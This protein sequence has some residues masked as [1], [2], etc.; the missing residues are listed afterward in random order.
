M[1]HI[2][3]KPF[4]PILL[5]TSGCFYTC[6]VFSNMSLRDFFNP[7]SLSF[8]EWILFL[9]MNRVLLLCIDSVAQLCCKRPTAYPESRDVDST[10]VFFLFVNCF[11]EN[12]FV[13][14]FS[15]VSWNSMRISRSVQTLDFISGPVGLGFIFILDDL[16]YYIFHRFL[17]ASPYL[18]ASIHRYHHKSTYPRRGYVDAVIEHPVEQVCALVL[19]AVAV[20][21]VAHCIRLHV[22]TLGVHLVLKALFSCWNHTGGEVRFLK[23]VYS[24]HTH[25]IHHAKL[26]YNFGQYLMLWDMLMGTFQE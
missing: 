4:Y 19:Y 26:K 6:I 8:S 9:F 1:D 23:P 20:T 11:V 22:F 7:W 14:L 16:F 17:H 3:I 21:T 5:T 15:F 18:Y 24:I 12:T 25:T 13:Q 10:D 2:P